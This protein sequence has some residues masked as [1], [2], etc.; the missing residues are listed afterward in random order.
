MGPND[1]ITEYQFDFSEYSLKAYENSTSVK[2]FSFQIKMGNKKDNIMRLE[3]PL[4]SDKNKELYWTA[5][6]NCTIELVPIM[7]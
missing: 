6:L 7:E 2:V 5:K 1:F 3:M 4:R